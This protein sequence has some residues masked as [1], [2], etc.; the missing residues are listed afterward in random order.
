MKSNHTPGPWVIETT[1]TDNI[2]LQGEDSDQ[3]AICD[4]ALGDANARVIAAAPEMLSLLEHLCSEITSV[5]R[6]A[7]LFEARSLIEKIEANF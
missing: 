6:E 2:I 3:I 1:D 4:R 5:E 7:I